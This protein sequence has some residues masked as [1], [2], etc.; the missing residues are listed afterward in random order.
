MCYFCK[1]RV[2]YIANPRIK[3]RLLCFRILKTKCG[4]LSPVFAATSSPGLD[5]L[6]SFLPGRR[7]LSSPLSGK[8]HKSDSCFSD[9]L[10]DG[11]AASKPADG[12][13]ETLSLCLPS[14]LRGFLLRPRLRWLKS[15]SSA[16][17]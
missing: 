16:G 11:S 5:L 15:L 17:I 4:N 9:F 1:S 8:G 6:S 2:E 7:L 3:S 14:T 10:P 13:L 12:F